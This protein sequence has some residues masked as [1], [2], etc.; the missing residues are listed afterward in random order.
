MIGQRGRF[1]F[2]GA[3]GW[4]EARGE[5]LIAPLVA[6]QRPTAAS[7]ASGVSTFQ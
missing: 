2:L 7:R 5:P 6:L 3:D 4:A 1:S